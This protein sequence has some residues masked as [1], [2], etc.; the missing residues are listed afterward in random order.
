MKITDITENH[1][2]KIRD[3]RILRLN[4]DTFHNSR[5]EAIIR[6]YKYE[7]TLCGFR[8]QPEYDIIEIF[9]II[10][11]VENTEV[12]DLYSGKYVLFGNTLHKVKTVW[13]NKLSLAEWFENS[14]PG[15]RCQV[16]ETEGIT[17]PMD[18]NKVL[19]RG[20]K[21]IIH[22]DLKEVWGENWEGYF[23]KGVV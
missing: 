18:V 11:S 20:H 10:R 9:E 12:M 2:V 21:S 8:D 1:F 22:E 15:D 16:V 6:L 7:D 13:D 5:Q 3:G 4:K 17:S 14:N 19:T 23:V